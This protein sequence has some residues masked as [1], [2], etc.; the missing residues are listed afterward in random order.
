MPDTDYIIRE[1]VDAE[2]RRRQQIPVPTGDGVVCRETG[3]YH[4][5]RIDQELSWGLHQSKSSTYDTVG[6]FI[7]RGSDLIG[8]PASI[9][10]I[11]GCDV[12]V[13]GDVRIYDVTNG[14]IV[15]EMIGSTAAYPSIV[16]LGTISNVPTG[17]ALWELQ[18]RKTA[19]GGNDD[20]LAAGVS[21]RF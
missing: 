14:M 17:E 18:V 15:A 6:I 9:K 4:F 19:G 13:T 10:A 11:F 16:D 3:S 8:T 20:V 12:G 21:V 2:F 1:T 5:V 7:F